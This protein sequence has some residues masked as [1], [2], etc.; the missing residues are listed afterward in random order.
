[1][2]FRL[3]NAVSDAEKKAESPRSAARSTSVVPRPMVPVWRL[4][5]LLACRGARG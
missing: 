3:N 5:S 2:R 4:L 1:M